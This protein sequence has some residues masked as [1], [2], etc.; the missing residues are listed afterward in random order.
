MRYRREGKT[1]EIGGRGEGKREERG[2]MEWRREMTIFG[3]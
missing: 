3:M 2:R 1:D